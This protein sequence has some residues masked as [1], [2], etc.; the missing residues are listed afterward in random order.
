MTL[1]TAAIA[2]LAMTVVL[3]M[4]SNLLFL[5]TFEFRL[6]WFRDPVRLLGA[7]PESAGLLRWAAV[8]DLFSYYLPTGVVV[9]AMWHALRPRSPALADAASLAGLGF[10]LAGSIGA[11]SLATAGPILLQA[12]DAPGAD[13]ATIE[14]A[15]AVLLEV[16]WRGIWQLLDAT[17]GGA[18]F[19]GVGLLMRIDHPW[20]ARLSIAAGGAAWLAAAAYLLGAGIAR[21]AALGM[22][23]IL[24]TA[25]S[26]WLI[27]LLRRRRAPFTTIG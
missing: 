6:D 22:L 21:D 2:A 18:W 4:I 20:F 25:W 7:G 27:V 12:H 10:V 16:V 11:V 14:T 17:L 15:F 24:W 1:R 23:F 8:T 5:W 19:V 3:G 13:Q 26:V 9:L